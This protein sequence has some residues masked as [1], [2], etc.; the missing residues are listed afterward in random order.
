MTSLKAIASDCPKD[1]GEY[2]DKSFL[3]ISPDLPCSTSTSASSLDL[4]LH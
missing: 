3:H 1:T 2:N 4:S